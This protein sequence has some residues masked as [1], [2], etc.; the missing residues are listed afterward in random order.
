MPTVGRKSYQFRCFSFAIQ[1]E[2]DRSDS[3]IFEKSMQIIH[4]YLLIEI[5]KQSFVALLYKKW[6]KCGTQFCYATLTIIKFY[7]W[8]IWKY[9][10]PYFDM[11][12]FPTSY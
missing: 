2:I 12:H 1:L 3:I 6:E 11:K 5:P 8:C 4:V 10:I 7:I 9:Q